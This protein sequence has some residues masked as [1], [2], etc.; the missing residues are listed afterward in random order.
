MDAYSCCDGLQLNGD[1]R[2]MWKMQDSQVVLYF[3]TLQHVCLFVSQQKL[4]AVCQGAQQEF[5]TGAPLERAPSLLWILFCQW[6]KPR[7]TLL[8]ESSEAC[9]I[10]AL[11][12]EKNNDFLIILI[13]IRISHLP[14]V[15][16]QQE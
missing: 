11:R 16:I 6:E 9:C 8:L 10:Y 1:V 3:E 2:L 15:A 5:S 12:P 14:I 13:D 7:R 4:L